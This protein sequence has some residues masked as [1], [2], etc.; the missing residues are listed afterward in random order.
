MRC[1]VF[2]I[3]SKIKTV[4]CDHQLYEAWSTVIRR[5]NGQLCLAF[6]G[7]RR[8]HICPFGRLEFMQSD[9][10]GDS[11]TW[12]RVVLD[13]ALDDRDGG[14]LETQ[15]GTL[16]I[17]TFTS[18]AYQPILK[19]AEQAAVEG[20]LPWSAQELGDWQQAH[21]R[22]LSSPQSQAG[23]WILRSTD[24]GASWSH[25]IPS[26]VNSPHGPTTLKS[27]SLL[28]AGK[29]LWGGE[30]RVGFSISHDDGQSWQWLSTLPTRPGDDPAHYHELHAV[31]ADNGTIIV[32]IRNWN[33][34]NQGETL[35]S[36][37]LDGGL[38]WSIPHEIG[39]WGLPSHLLK[40]SDGRLMMTYGYRREPFGNQA[41]ISDNHGLT[42]S[43]P[44]TISDDGTCTDLGYPSTVELDSHHFLTIW[45]ERKR[46]E[47]R[48]ILR[49]AK[50]S[51]L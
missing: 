36:E 17:S 1:M 37:S 18:D 38:S 43:D 51:I 28:Y 15:K 29:E 33:E 24:G 45:Y 35:Q 44:I 31:E 47:K 25:P 5:R 2:L 14:L 39:V 32:Q 20:T 21:H 26:L 3:S 49:Q 34:R 42:W 6:S 48:A 4:S 12:P 13:T 9:D 27:G 23:Q 40:L 8:R 19:K 10:N 22:T 16:I 50:W 7:G 46:D 30:G 41:R 11:W